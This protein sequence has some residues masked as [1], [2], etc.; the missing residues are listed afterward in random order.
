MYPYADVPVMQLS[1]DSRQGPMYHFRLGELLRPLRDEG[2]LIIGSGGATHNLRYVFHSA[3]G[4][5]TPE[6]VVGFREWL[7]VTV[8]NDQRDD[9][10]FYR[11]RGSYAAQNHP[12]EEHFL[13]LLGAMGP[14]NPASHAN[15]FTRVKHTVR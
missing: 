10:V 14:Q 11:V 15:A 13:P 7:A 6:W 8:E 5:P 9:L 3:P 4:D 12:A 1:I 2:V